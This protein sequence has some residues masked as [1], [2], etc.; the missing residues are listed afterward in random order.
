MSLTETKE[1]ENQY[2]MHTYG[3]E[4]VKFVKGDGCHL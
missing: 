3:R 4:D 2:I 1:L